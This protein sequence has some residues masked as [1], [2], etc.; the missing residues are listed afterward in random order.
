M[1][2]RRAQKVHGDRYDY[3]KVEYVRAISASYINSRW[4]LGALKGPGSNASGLAL[5]LTRQPDDLAI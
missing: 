4:R 5:R 1:I 2:F 3:S